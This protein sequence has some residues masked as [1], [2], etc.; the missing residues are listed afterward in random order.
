M[1]YK[2]T[3]LK[4]NIT[5]FQITYD[6]PKAYRT[7]NLLDRLMVRMDHRLFDTQYFHGTLNQAELGIRTWTLIHNFAPSTALLENLMVGKAQLN[8]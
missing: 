3:K 7:S 1:L 8:V 6:H 5:F 2:I 4:N